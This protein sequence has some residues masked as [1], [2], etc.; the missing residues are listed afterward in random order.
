MPSTTLKTALLTFITLGA[1]TRPALACQCVS[2][3]KNAQDMFSQADVVFFGTKTS[4]DTDFE[5]TRFRIQRLIK[6]NIKLGSATFEIDEILPPGNFPSM[7]TGRYEENKSYIVFAKIDPKDGALHLMSDKCYTDMIT[8]KDA[9]SYVYNGKEYPDFPF[10]KEMPGV[11]GN[12]TQPIYAAE[13]KE[14]SA[15]EAALHGV[16]EFLRQAGQLQ[17]EQKWVTT[18]AK[19]AP[20]DQHGQPYWEI[21]VEDPTLNAK[22]GFF[23]VSIYNGLSDGVIVRPGE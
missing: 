1:L 14:K 8:V 3:Y 20:H 12:G 17:P 16:R 7:C 4:A 22:G 18:A 11:A 9:E 2:T 19:L 10:F 23:I 21:K 15:R 5:N 6:S 13:M